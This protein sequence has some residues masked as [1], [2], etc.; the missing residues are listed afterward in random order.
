VG[1]STVVLSLLNF[2]H[3][4]AGSLCSFDYDLFDVLL[5]GSLWF[6]KRFSE[7]VWNRNLCA[8]A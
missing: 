7:P 8:I 5:S 2:I 3:A 6:W 4:C 1:F